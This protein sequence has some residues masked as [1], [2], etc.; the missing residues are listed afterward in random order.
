MHTL[1]CYWLAFWA[2]DSPDPVLTECQRRI[3]TAI[4]YL[5]LAGLV[6]LLAWMAAGYWLA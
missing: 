2:G 3:D 5:C 1:K 4:G 6:G